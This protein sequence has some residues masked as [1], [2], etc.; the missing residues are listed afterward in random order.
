MSVLC[1]AVSVSAQTPI[2]FAWDLDP[3]HEAPTGGSIKWDIE[4]DGVI[5]P[6]GSVTVTSTDRRCTASIASGVHTFRLHGV[7]TTDTGAVISG[8]WSPSLTQTTGTAP[9]VYVISSVVESTAPPPTFPVT[10][11]GSA[12][13]YAVGTAFTAVEPSASIGN[14]E[15]MIA[16]GG[17][18][19]S[20]TTVNLPP[21]WAIIPSLSGAQDNIV[22]RVGYLIRGSTAPN[23][24]VAYTGTDF[25]AAVVTTVQSTG[26]TIKID[27]ISSIGTSGNGAVAPNPPAT[28]ANASTALSLALGM[29]YAGVQWLPPLGYIEHDGTTTATG[30]YGDIGL[31]FKPLTTA[32]VEDPGPFN[33]VGGVFP[34]GGW[35]N[36]FTMTL[37]A[38]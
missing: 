11:K 20:T 22:W 37:T 36:G 17:L 7:K 21:G 34:S 12:F 23:M 4:V 15:L 13:S 30:G 32:G 27:S 5:K 14:F 19:T 35:W 2:T 28:I 3:S 10:W 38:N 18:T 29:N 26:G 1:M 8:A 9:G 31:A 33:A 6:C 25:V 24:N 16:Y